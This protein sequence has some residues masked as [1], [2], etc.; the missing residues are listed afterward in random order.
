MKRKVIITTSSFDLSNFHQLNDLTAAGIE[1][2]QNPLNRRL[3]EQEVAHLLSDDVVAMIAGLAVSPDGSVIC[4]LL[5]SPLANPDSYTGKRST[6]TR[7]LKIE[8]RSGKILGQYVY[9]LDKPNTFESD[10]KS[11]RRK[12]NEVRLS[13]MVMIGDDRLLVVERINKTAKFYVVS[14]ADGTLIKTG[15]TV[16][17]AVGRVL[18]NHMVTTGHTSN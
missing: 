3:S 1:I 17:D 18:G 11:A 9:V 16:R 6:N 10:N 8:R 14:L 7:L 2:I 5:Q 13:E 12:Q 15:R 4:I